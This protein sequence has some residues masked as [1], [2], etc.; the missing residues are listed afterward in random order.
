MFSWY[1]ITYFRVHLAWTFQF[2]RL[3][4]TIF[5]VRVPFW[6]MFHRC[7]NTVTHVQHSAYS[8]TWNV[9]ELNYD[10]LTFGNERNNWNSIKYISFG[11][12]FDRRQHI[13]LSRLH[14]IRL[15]THHAYTKCDCYVVDCL[16]VRCLQ[17][18][19]ICWSFNNGTI[20]VVVVSPA[21]HV[22]V[23]FNKWPSNGILIYMRQLDGIH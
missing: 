13:V 9:V 18:P 21:M 14:L 2:Y 23:I 17:M 6:K 15:R 22:H 8:Q 7:P 3:S 5:K 16:Y 12:H 19:I 20:R 10:K 1:W 11:I 4:N